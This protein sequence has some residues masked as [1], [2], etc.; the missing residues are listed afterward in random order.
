MREAVE[1]G[2]RVLT[3]GR[4]NGAQVEPTVL[5]DVKPS[6]QRGVR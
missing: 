6:M 2:A 5:V 3:G 4:R 1:Q